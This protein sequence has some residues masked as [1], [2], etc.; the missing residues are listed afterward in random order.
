[1]EIIDSDP[2]FWAGADGVTVL[3]LLLS[4][5]SLLWQAGT[6][7]RQG[8]SVKF[9]MRILP[10]ETHRPIP[11]LFVWMVNRGRLT[12]VTDFL[13]LVNKETKEIESAPLNLGD[14][15]T[16]EDGYDYIK[17]EP[18]GIFSGRISIPEF[19]KACEDRSIKWEDAR[20][21]MFVSG[22]DINRRLPRKV[23]RQIK[24]FTQKAQPKDSPS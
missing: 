20:F 19:L 14:F 15:P 23:K 16:M 1:M 22:R 12:A 24:D 21:Y 2:G 17:L 6:W 7:F 10:T 11:E 13:Y 18:G 5:I 4:G 3:A 8:A 9:D